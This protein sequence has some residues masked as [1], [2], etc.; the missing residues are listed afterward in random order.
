[1]PHL[2]IRRKM[3][4]PVQVELMKNKRATIHPYTERKLEGG[5]PG[6]LFISLQKRTLIGPR[7]GGALK[8]EQ[9]LC[10]ILYERQLQPRG[11]LCFPRVQSHRAALSRLLNNLQSSSFVFSI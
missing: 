6:M 3:K 4:I 10:F 2:W 9:L 8:K 1:M 7:G 11:S 5:F